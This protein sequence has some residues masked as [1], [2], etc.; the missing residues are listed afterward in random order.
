MVDMAAENFTQPKEME[1]QYLNQWLLTSE[2]S[3]TP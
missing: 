3:Q 1:E 2:E